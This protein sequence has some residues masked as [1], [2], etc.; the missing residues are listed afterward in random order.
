MV[1]ILLLISVSAMISYSAVEIGHPS[2]KSIDACA[3]IAQVVSDRSASCSYPIMVMVWLS[4]N[5]LVLVD[6]VTLPRTRL[7]L[8]YGRVNHLGM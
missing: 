7:T 6:I 1:H 4:G 5:A 8:V 2:T 3:T